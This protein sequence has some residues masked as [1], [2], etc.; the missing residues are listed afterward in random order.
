M[1]AIFSLVALLGLTAIAAGA[2][3]PQKI[4]FNRDIRSILSDNCYACHG[5]DKNKRKADLRLDQEDGGAFLEHKGKFPI[6]AGNDAKS[7]LILRI[8]SADPDV[9]MPPP[10]FGKKLT[11]R[12]ID[13]LR[14][15]IEQGAKW[16]ALWSF[17]PP[18][19]SALPEVKNAAW[20]RNPIDRFVLARLESEG[21]KPSPEAEKTTLIRR[22]YLDLLGLPPTP[23]EVD[24]FL[25]DNRPDAYE[26]L[27]DELLANPH[28][29]ERMALDWLDAARFAD[30]H[31]YHIDSGRDMTAWREW[32]IDAFNRDLPYDQF[33]IQQLAGDLLPNATIDEKIASGFMRNNMVNF[34]GGAIPEEYHAAYIV[35]RV[36]TFG[37]VWL[38]L[39]VGCCQCHD[40]KFDPIT[41]KEYYQ[42]FA[43]F[44]H[45]PE[46]G[47]D[48]QKG[49]AVPFIK[50]PAPAQK[51]KLDE[52]AA[53]KQK[54][55]AQL[56]APSAEFDAAQVEWEKTIANGDDV[57]EWTALSPT[58]MKDTGGA[59]F[60]LE[61]DKSIYVRGLNPTNDTY[62]ITATADLTTIT[63]IRLEALPDDRLHGRGPGRSENG[64]IVLTRVRLKVGPE[65]DAKSA[66]LVKLKAAIADFSQDN[67]PISNAIDPNPK[68]KNGWAIFPQAG[69]AHS[70]AFA[71]DQPLD[72]SKDSVLTFV[73][74]FKSPFAQH[75]LGK[76]RLSVTGSQNPLGKNSIPAEIQKILVIAADARTPSQISDLRKYFRVN[77]STANKEVAEKFAKLQQEQDDVEATER[78]TMVMEEMS[79]P[80]ET[81]ILLRGQ[82]DKVGDMVSPGV[83]KSL[84]PP[85][86]GAPDNRL[87]LAE[88]VVSPSNPLPARVAVNRFWQSFFGTGIVKTPGDFGSQ[89]EEPSHPA[90]LDWLACEFM[91]PQEG[92]AIAWDTKHI[93]R[94]IV[95]SATYRQASA[96][97]EE[98][99]ARDPEDRLL[100]HA[101]RLRLPA[102]YIR[103][104]ALAVSGLLDA[105][106]GGT[107]VS[108]YQPPGLW[109][110][111]MSR[112]DGAKWTAQVYKQDHG[113]DLYR[114]TMYTFWKRTSPPPTLLAFDAPDRETCTVRRS[115][116]NTPLQALVLMNDPTYVEASRKLAERMMTEGGNSDDSRITF[117]YRL[118]MARS[119]NAEETTMLKNLYNEEL[120]SFK[121]DPDAA[122]KLLT[123]GESPRNTKLDQSELAAWST[124]A[125]VVLNLDET[126]TKD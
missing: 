106:I 7:E 115:R 43:Y 94:L 49:N 92:H 96:T 73:L 116:T 20:C 91:K 65:K 88:W 79:K 25:N 76:F 105:R 14:R 118:A 98:M 89:G 58:S 5:P 93:V 81:H 85:P 83:P 32:V 68:S 1:K 123:V 35:D 75:Q 74:E 6:V 29:G 125:S 90:L 28:Y 8:T 95:T 82:Y 42:L 54:V 48:G 36:N 34:E 4:E 26:R 71:L 9:H 62:T 45:V 21:L 122:E 110:E 13:L 72:V 22:L 66:K 56:F 38:G 12:Q 50:T 69:Q 114:R 23:A 27:V 51:Q 39:T 101:P 30:T 44:N 57:V 61:Q 17:I 77:V 24:Q 37:T 11:D 112:G 111:L 108:P 41:Q 120:A 78:T 104:Q 113:P 70:A 16:Q 33:T 2:E 121:S 117:A 55:E 18:Q 19:R 84:P 119:P 46:N 10:D 107:S 60:D 64:N 15:W 59:F 67:F 80:R 100:E 124:V 52:I 40:H 102:E 99:L 103:D 97:N 3:L 31:G 53:E 109:E 87:G 126:I 86:A 63:G 47:L